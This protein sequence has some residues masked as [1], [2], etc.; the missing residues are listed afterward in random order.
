MMHSFNPGL[1]RRSLVLPLLLCASMASLAAVPAA[2]PGKLPAASPKPAAVNLPKLAADQVIAR[3]V[4]AVGGERAWQGVQAMT[5]SGKLDAGRVRRDGGYIPTNPMEAKQRAR[6]LGEQILEGKYKPPEQKVIQLPFTLS[7]ARPGSQRIEIPFQGQ[8]AVQVFDGSSGWKLRPFI[9][10]HEVEAY[11]P[12]ELA[13][14]QH[15]QPLDG[16]LVGYAAKGTRPTVRAAEL[17][18]GKA[19][20]RLSLKFSKGPERSIWIDGKSFLPL[21]LED[22][23]RRRDGHNRSVYT[24]FRDY[25]EVEGLQIPFVRETH[26]DGQA[27]VERILVEK[28]ALNPALPADTFAKPR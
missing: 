7:L 5:L 14:A 11:S 23:P 18:E 20:Y 4:A 21:K 3:S 10:R 2:A 15:D 25:R 28:V 1:R 8:T 22:E 17:V 6:V 16:P 26:V 24:Y 12:E 9:G 19:A 27:D 13:V